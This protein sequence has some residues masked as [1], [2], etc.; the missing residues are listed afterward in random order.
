MKKN[1]KENI[2]LNKVLFV[3][4]IKRIFS[5]QMQKEAS[6]YIKI[7]RVLSV[8]PFTHKNFVFNV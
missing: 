1:K 7:L 3:N 6:N 2:D 5:K 8:L 4:Q